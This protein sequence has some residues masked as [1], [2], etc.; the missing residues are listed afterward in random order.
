[1]D[2][3]A[4]YASI[5]PRYPELQGKV[6]LVTGSGRGIGSAIATRLA[7]ERMKIVV[8]GLEADQVN[9]TTNALRDLGNTAIGVTSDF[10]T[11]EGVER[12][13]K[14][15][16][17]TYNTIDLLVNNAA[18]L[19]R[20][21]IF[22]V[23]LALLESHLNINIRGAYLC[24]QRAAESMRKNG[25]NIVNISS[26]GGLRAHWRGLPYDVTKGAIDAMTR[27]M[28]LELA[29]YNIR[30]NAVAPGAISTRPSDS[31]P[32]ELSARIPLGRL[33]APVEIASAVAFLAS[34]EAK[35]ITGQVLYVDGGISTQLSPS[36]Q[37]I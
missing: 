12:V 32:E 34:D 23:E 11:V 14:E 16:L 28:A 29:S 19:K 30:V 3:S 6:A 18:I 17:D 31:Y 5:Q 4:L 7:R 10:S 20:E 36:G 8:H 26:V 35:Y 22:E 37:P 15:T 27:A 2:I 1:M 33:G 25:G 9:L 13:V 24:S 21:H